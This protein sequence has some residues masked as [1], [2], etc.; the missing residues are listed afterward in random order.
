MGAHLV[1]GKFQ[2]DKYPSCPAG[3]VPL[4]TADASA[5]DL[6]YTYAQRRRV[7]DPEF[8]DDLGAAL[9]ADGFVPGLDE[10]MSLRS[11]AD[12]IWAI[13]KEMDVGDTP[14]ALKALSSKLHGLAN[15][16]VRPR[17]RIAQLETALQ[18]AT[19]HSPLF[20][21]GKIASAEEAEKR[22]E[23]AER[24]LKAVSAEFLA[25]Q[26]EKRELQQKLSMVRMG[27]G[28]VW[29]WEGGGADKVAT[30]SCP[31]VMAADT[32]RELEARGAA[33]DRVAELERLLA[34][35]KAA[36]EGEVDLDAAALYVEHGRLTM[37]LFLEGIA[38][39]DIIRL[40][41][42]RSTLDW[43]ELNG[44]FEGLVT[45]VMGYEE[46]L[47]ERRAADIQAAVEADRKARTA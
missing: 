26:A 39:A 18:A 28:D 46:R 41:R 21:L 23:E 13:A 31:V 43:V 17:E 14:R 11:I 44:R 25:E 35:C 5:Q 20:L 6:L 2:S 40:S 1:N 34:D 7:V 38:T 22:A 27:A 12:E 42:V 32:A 3:K 36:T 19:G 10:R 9:A 30:L 37:Q 15:E 24:K 16:S 47:R 29:F 33:A 45:A 8:S 4:S